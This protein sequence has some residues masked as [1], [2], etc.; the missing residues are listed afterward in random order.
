MKCMH[1]LKIWNQALEISKRKK[2]LASPKIID[3]LEN[4]IICNKT[5]WLTMDQ[6]WNMLKQHYL[7]QLFS[8]LRGWCRDAYWQSYDFAIDV[9][10]KMIT[11]RYKKVDTSFIYNETK[12]TIYN[13]TTE[14]QSKDGTSMQSKVIKWR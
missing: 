11:Y 14:Y 13:K 9:W 12:K 8:K 4:D 3:L 10:I 6:H 1:V 5:S 7:K 2:V